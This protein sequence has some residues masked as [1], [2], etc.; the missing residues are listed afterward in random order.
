MEPES[1]K[2]KMLSGELYNPLDVQ[3]V[4]ERRRAR[5]LTRRFNDASPDD[6]EERARLITAL[7]SSVGRGVQ[8]EPPFYCDY[9]TNTTIGENVFINFNCAILDVT[10]V[11]IGSRTM[12]GP[13]VQIYT[14]THPLSA[15]GRRSG[16][17]LGQPVEIGDDVWIG[18]GAIIL[19]GVKIG[20]GAVIGAGSVVT[21][22]IPKGIVAVGNPCRAIR[23]I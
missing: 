14:A 18:G 21:R 2:A 13:S 1:E 10:S 6:T 16:L 22:D 5:H 12:I 8:I 4:T 9:G 3:L 19:P 15:A 11:R 17:E 7:F 23:S 20:S